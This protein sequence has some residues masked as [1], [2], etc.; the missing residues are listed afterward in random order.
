MAYRA[1]DDP[2]LFDVPDYS[3]SETIVVLDGDELAYIVSAVCEQRCLVYTNTVNEVEMPFKN[4]TL[5]KKFMQGLT[6][7]EGHFTV[8]EKQVAEPAQNAFSTLK[9]KLTKTRKKFETDNIEIYISGVDN[10]RDNIPLPN[11]YKGNRDGLIRPLLL[12]QCKDYLVKYHNAKVVDGVEADDWL[13]I[14]A[15]DGFSTG[16]KIIAC[17][18]DKDNLG[19]S[20]WYFNPEKENAEMMYIEGLGELYL[21]TSNK[22]PK[23]AGQGRKW[24]YYQWIAG[25]SAD[26]YEPRDIAKQL[27]IKLAPFGDK[28]A[29]KLLQDLNTDKE[30]IQAVHDL[31][32]SWYGTEFVT[33]TVWDGSEL[34][35]D[36][37]GIMQIYLDCARM[38]RWENDHVKVPDML[39]KM[40]ITR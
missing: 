6:V 29:L 20:G 12:D 31:F 25:D 23:V 21:D 28:S 35:T 33:Y 26:H 39:N 8:E 14:R 15:Y 32:K 11:K 17:S 13:A 4:K 37:V 22:T 38:L 34:T 36:Y 27:G 16:K 2:E 5:F 9:A 7:P 19:N 10:F 30:C 24:L 40:G 1:S 18:Q 3:K